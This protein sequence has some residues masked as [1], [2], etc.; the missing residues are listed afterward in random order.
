MKI[1]IY[2]LELDIKKNPEDEN[3]VVQIRHKK[4]LILFLLLVPVAVD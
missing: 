2:V 3:S 1:Q 4:G